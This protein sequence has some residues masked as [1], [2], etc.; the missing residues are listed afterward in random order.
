MNRI[1]L[2]VVVVVMFG[3]PKMASA[4]VVL[5]QNNQYYY[6]SMMGTAHF[7]QQITAGISGLLDHIDL[8]TGKGTTEIR[9]KKGG[10]VQTSSP[11]LFDQT[12]T[13]TAGVN[14]ID[15]SAYNIS[16]NPGDLFVVD[17]LGGS[18]APLLSVSGPY[19]AYGHD[20]SGGSLWGYMNNTWTT[21]IYGGS[22]DLEF[23]TFVNDPPAAT[24]EPATLAL[25]GCG[26]VSFALYR[27]RTAS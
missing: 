20:Y 14:H 3:I 13:F 17:W 16:L 11:W 26:L 7:Q 5:D 23:Q 9:I 21:S 24:P 22:W 4:A 19:G 6:T 25:F 12:I 27:R 1:L 2:T 15:L 10:A 18:K 8:Y